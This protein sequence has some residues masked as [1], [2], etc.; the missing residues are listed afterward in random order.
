MTMNLILI[1]RSCTPYYENQF[2]SKQKDMYHQLSH[3]FSFE[4][5]ISVYSTYLYF[6]TQKYT[7]NLQILQRASA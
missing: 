5:A 3:S 4:W 7:S 1:H 2:Y 6:N